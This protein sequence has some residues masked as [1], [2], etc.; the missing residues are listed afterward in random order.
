MTTELPVDGQRITGQRG[1]W[2]PRG[3]TFESYEGTVDFI[4][5]CPGPDDPCIELT[6]GL[7]IFPSLGDTWEAV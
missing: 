6:N 7:H 4:W 1:V 2:S 5:A 3:K